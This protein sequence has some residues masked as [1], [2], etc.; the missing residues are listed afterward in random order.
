MNAPLDRPLR[1]IPRVRNYDWGTTDFIPRLCGR[2]PTGRPEAELWFG[3]HPDAPAGV[4]L[5]AGSGDDRNGGKGPAPLDRLI[6][7]RRDEILGPRATGDALPFLTKILSA[8]RPLSIQAHPNRDQA[9]RGFSAETGSADGISPADRTYRDPNH[10]PELLYALTRFD[11]LSGFRPAAEASSHFSRASTGSSPRAPPP[12]GHFSKRSRGTPVPAS[13]PRPP[14]RLAGLHPKARPTVARVFS[15]S[16]ASPGPIWTIRWSWRRSSSASF[17]SIP[18]KPSS[19]DP[20][21]RTATW[22]APRS[23]SWR[24]PTT[25]CASV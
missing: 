20:A 9:L 3:G 17:G 5:G 10:K 4:V 18:A 14:T 8:A 13:P 15:G 22:K 12:T 24:T 19:P 7:D 2:E 16:P 6:A 25:C 21:Y 1:L 11:A 23:R